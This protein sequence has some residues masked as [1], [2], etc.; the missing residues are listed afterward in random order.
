M[1]SLEANYGHLIYW[2]HV[3]SQRFRRKCTTLTVASFFSSVQRDRSTFLFICSTSSTWTTDV[4]NILEHR[5]KQKH[6]RPEPQKHR[7]PRPF[8]VFH[9]YFFRH[10][11][12]FL[13]FFGFR[14]EVC[15][16]IL[17]HNG[18]QKI[19]KGPLFTFFGTVTLFKN[20]I[21]FFWNRLKFSK[22]SPVNFFIFCNQLEFHK[23]QRVPPFTILS[24]RYS[25]DFGRSRLVYHIAIHDVTMEDKSSINGM[26]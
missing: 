8:S 12:I 3:F 4:Q 20:L 5:P 1:T 18:C 6:R 17:Q 9:S 15:F 25:A 23:A 24:L 2:K 22:G 14:S 16:D 7:I 13:K 26:C 10:C 21:N 11:A 19:P